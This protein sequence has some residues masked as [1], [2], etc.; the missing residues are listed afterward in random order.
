MRQN[1]YSTRL[2]YDE[3]VNIL[4]F[5]DYAPS[6]PIYYVD[7]GSPTVSPIAGLVTRAQMGVFKPNPRFALTVV[8]CDVAVPISAKKALL[9]LEW[10]FAMLEEFQA[11]QMNDT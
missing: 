7:N 4:D 10:K 3:F 9:L 2:S 1:L 6:L 11:L 8:P 5:S